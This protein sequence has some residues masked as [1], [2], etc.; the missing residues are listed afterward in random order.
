LNQHIKVLNYTSKIKNKNK[1]HIFLERIRLAGL[2][3]WNYKFVSMT[4]P[5]W[6]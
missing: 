1:N 2:G 5:H 6:I 3:I 4:K